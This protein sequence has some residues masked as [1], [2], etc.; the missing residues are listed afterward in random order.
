MRS[1]VRLCV[2][3]LHGCRPV[4]HARCHGQPVVVTTLRR[5]SNQCDK[6]RPGAGCCA[7]F[8]RFWEMLWWR[9]SPLCVLV[10]SWLLVRSAMPGM[11]VCCRSRRKAR[12]S[13]TSVTKPTGLVAVLLCYS[14]TV[15]IVWW[16]GRDLLRV[17]YFMVAV[18]VLAAAGHG[19][20]VVVTA[21]TSHRPTGV[22]ANRSGAALPLCSRS[23]GD[24]SVA[25]RVCCVC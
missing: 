3:G 19:Q 25:R 20:P 23:F 7:L 4:S 18:Q 13:P 6:A 14:S 22:T 11:A 2:D 15:E 24:V 5:A 10:V 17:M 1:D 8:S 16:R 21:S 9:S 12:R